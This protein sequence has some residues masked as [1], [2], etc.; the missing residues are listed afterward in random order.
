MQ[1]LPFRTRVSSFE[2]IGGIWQAILMPCNRCNYDDIP[3]VHIITLDEAPNPNGGEVLIEAPCVGPVGLGNTFMTARR[4]ADGNQ[5]TL[6]YTPEHVANAVHF[7][8][9]APKP[10]RYNS[11]Y[12]IERGDV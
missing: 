5:M 3:D 6:V 1:T 4:Y 7:T 2:C 8:P 11:A 12:R 10:K 9:S